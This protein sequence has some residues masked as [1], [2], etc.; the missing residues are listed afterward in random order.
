MHDATCEVCG[1]RFM[2]YTNAKYCSTACAST[3]KRRR[4]KKLPVSDEEFAKLPNSRCIRCGAETR[5]PASKYC[6]A[7]AAI[8]RAETKSKSEKKCRLRKRSEEPFLVG[9]LSPLER[10]ARKPSVTHDCY[11]PVRHARG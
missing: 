1:G 2:T 9:G 10:K 11:L 3:A 6:N 5:T 7:C 8:A 4:A